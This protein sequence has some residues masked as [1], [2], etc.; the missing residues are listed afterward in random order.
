MLSCAVTL[1]KEAGWK[2]EP[3]A[4]F[5]I[6]AT[7]KSTCHKVRP[8]PVCPLNQTTDPGS[9]ETAATLLFHR[10]DLWPLQPD[11]SGQ[12]GAPTLVGRE[13]LSDWTIKKIPSVHGEL[14]WEWSAL[15]QSR[16]TGAAGGGQNGCRGVPETL[17]IL[18]QAWWSSFRGESAT[19]YSL[20]DTNN[21]HY[22]LRRRGYGASL[23]RA[24]LTH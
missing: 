20:C 10:P 16:P 15:T 2:M 13:R 9:T 4:V 21:L 17:R 11:S 18:T 24:S 7:E 1:Q 8:R 12:P 3:T 22:T 19:C 6:S 5:V 14:C 23:S